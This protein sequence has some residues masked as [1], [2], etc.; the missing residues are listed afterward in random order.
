MR[1]VT[2]FTSWVG[3]KRHLIPLTLDILAGGPPAKRI[4][5]PFLGGGAIEL[6][7]MDR[8]RSA[9][10]FG[11][12]INARLIN[13][14]AHAVASPSELAAILRFLDAEGDREQEIT[15]MNAELAPSTP[16]DAAAFIW[17]TKRSFSSLYRVN[18]KNKFNAAPDTQ[19]FRPVPTEDELNAISELLLDRALFIQRTWD[20]LLSPYNFNNFAFR[21]GDL[22][23]CDPP[24][25]GTFDGYSGM[26]WNEQ[27][28][29]DLL[30]GCRN[31]SREGAQ[32]LFYELADTM[33]SRLIDKDFPG[34]T[35]RVYLR[36]KTHFMNGAAKSQPAE[37]VCLLTAT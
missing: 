6:G 5:S 29:H 26:A 37:C 16:Y 14:W 2:P 23:I 19:K 13:A 15:R 31:A 17:L 20:A 21:P 30:L 18:K 7:L 12:D 11:S 3:G 28:L 33:I 27:S 25:L 24:Y 4:F 22:I 9:E 10:F 32:I 36:H 34:L 35:T 1:Q 8:W